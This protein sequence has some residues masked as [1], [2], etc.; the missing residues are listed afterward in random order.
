M[1]TFLLNMAF[2]SLCLFATATACNAMHIGGDLVSF[3]HYP[4]VKGLGLTIAA[5]PLVIMDNK[6]QRAALERVTRIVSKA[7][8]IAAKAKEDISGYIITPSYIRS[9]YTILNGQTQYQ[10]EV[11]DLAL[12]S[13][14]PPRPLVRGI[15]DND[16]GFVYSVGLFID[17]RKIGNTNVFL[18][19]Y[20]NSSVFTA[21]GATVAD[22]QIF[23]NG[24]LNIKVGSTVFLDNYSTY[25]FYDVQQTQQSSATNYSQFNLEDAQKTFDPY[26]L[27]SGKADNQFQLNLKNYQVATAPVV[28]SSTSLFENV[29][30]LYMSMIVVKN[31]ANAITYY[32]EAMSTDD[33]ANKN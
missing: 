29:V 31:G 9:E 12:Q 20:P 1:K 32:Q 27:V 5:T 28:A 11:R 17:Y 6:N 4:T 21:S 23:Y 2:L 14:T 19:S 18:Q 7:V 15:K 25:N 8:A 16:L 10:F 22:L 24:E 33:Q 26:V 30:T 13:G 3:I